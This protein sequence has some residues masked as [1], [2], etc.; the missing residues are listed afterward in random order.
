M[1][2]AAAVIALAVAVIA[3]SDSE[4][5]PKPLSEPGEKLYTLRGRAVSRDAADNTLRVDHEAIPGFMDAMTM[6]YSVRGAT[7]SVLPP[8]GARVEAKLHV[9]NSGYW[10][11]D[12]KKV[13]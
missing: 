10:L 3:C 13:P 11:T 8:D 9:T 2:A 7:V 12:V 4:K 6:D 5:K 1:R